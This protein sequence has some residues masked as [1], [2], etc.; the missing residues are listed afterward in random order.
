MAEVVERED[1]LFEQVSRLIDERDFV[2][3]TFGT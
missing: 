2:Q 3:K 1:A